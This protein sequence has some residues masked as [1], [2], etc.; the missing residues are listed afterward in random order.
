MAVSIPGFFAFG[1]SVG[2]GLRQKM[3]DSRVDRLDIGYVVETGLI[4]GGRVDR[5][6]KSDKTCNSFYIRLICYYLETKHEK[7]R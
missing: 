5:V 3:A 1:K 4:K 6:V 2:T 7:C